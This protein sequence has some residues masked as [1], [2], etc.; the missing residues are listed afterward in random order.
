MM[1]VA[2]IGTGAISTAHI[3]GYLEFQD[4]CK[5]VAMCDIYPEKAEKQAKEF[6]LDAAVFSDYQELVKQ[7]N[8]DLVS[9]CTPPYTHADIA[10]AALNHGKHVLVEK[11]MASS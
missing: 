6:N 2:I 1:N 7:E 4:R 5:I 10:I 9:V 3:R 11:P 8:I